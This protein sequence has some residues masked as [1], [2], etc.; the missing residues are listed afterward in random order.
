MIICRASLK[1]TASQLLPAIRAADIPVR[2]EEITTGP[3]ADLE[4]MP[5]AA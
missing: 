2:L 3:G 5:G 4:E 1:V